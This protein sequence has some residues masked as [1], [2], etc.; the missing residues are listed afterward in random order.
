MLSIVAQHMLPLT[1]VSF[2]LAT[3]L[4]V[5]Q[6]LIINVF[7]VLSFIITLQ[8]YDN[9]S[10][11][12]NK[13][14]ILHYGFYSLS[15]YCGSPPPTEDPPM[16]PSPYPSL[17]KPPPFYPLPRPQNGGAQLLTKIFSRKIG[18][19][20]RLPH[21]KKIKRK[22]MRGYPFSQKSVF[23]KIFSQKF[24][25]SKNGPSQKIFPEIL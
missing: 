1:F 16:D 9:Y 25:V 18:S 19:K 13:N 24:C 6:S 22:F 14:Y 21:I 20:K 4:P 8:R 23:Q 17:R 7:I 2:F 3:T 11:P 15:L 10:K 12:Q 5:L